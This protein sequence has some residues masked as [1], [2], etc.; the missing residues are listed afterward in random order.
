MV[1][2]V[3][4]GIPVFFHDRGTR[5]ILPPGKDPVS[6]LPEAGC[7]PGPVWTG[8]KYRP[9]RDSIPGSPARSQ[10]L[11]RL[12]HIHCAVGNEIRVQFRRRAV[13]KRL[14]WFY[15]LHC[16]SLSLKENLCF[17]LPMRTIPST[18]L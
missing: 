1:Q 5:S 7:A 14:I 17:I 13:L 6:I 10:S 8:G 12:S 11:Y 9:H 2:R 3:G 16:V 15:S 18:W 4:R